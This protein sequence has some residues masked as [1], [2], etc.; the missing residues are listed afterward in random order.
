MLF[1]A[2]SR[3]SYGRGW[4]IFTQWAIPNLPY[5]AVNRCHTSPGLD[6]SLAATQLCPGPPSE[7]QGLGWPLTSP[8]WAGHC[9]PASEHTGHRASYWKGNGTWTVWE[10]CE[11]SWQLQ[12]S[13]ASLWNTLK[14]QW[15]QCFSTEVLRLI[16]QPSLSL[17][18]YRHFTTSLNYKVIWIFS[19]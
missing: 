9:S 8:S 18:V 2:G 13:S 4:K 12:H 7:P 3:K 16:T 11:G 15:V 1:L 19:H 14:T 5:S 17:P 10:P 6:R